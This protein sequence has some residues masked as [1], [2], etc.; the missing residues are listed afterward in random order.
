MSSNAR[1]ISVPMISTN[2]DGSGLY[3]CPCCQEWNDAEEK[4]I[5]RCEYC[6]EKYRAISPNKKEKNAKIIAIVFRGRKPNL[7]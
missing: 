5:V 2:A 4:D 3:Q 1:I 7:F 6:A